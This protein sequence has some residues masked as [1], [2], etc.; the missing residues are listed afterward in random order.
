MLCI[1]FSPVGSLNDSFQKNVSVVAVGIEGAELE[2]LGEIA[3]KPSYI[4]EIKWADIKDE[5]SKAAENIQK[6]ILSLFEQ[7]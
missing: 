7:K 3:S 2:E 4:E 6:T 5:K 1:E